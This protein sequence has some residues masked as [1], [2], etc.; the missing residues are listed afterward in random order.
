MEVSKEIIFNPYEFLVISIFIFFIGLALGI[1][2]TTQI[3][4]WITY[5][6]RKDEEGYSENNKVI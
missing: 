4:N 5:N 1:Y 2:I 6:I 3:G